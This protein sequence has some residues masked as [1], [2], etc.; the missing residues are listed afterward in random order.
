[1][2]IPCPACLTA[3]GRNQVGTRG[4]GGGG[5]GGGGLKAFNW[6]T[7]STESGKQK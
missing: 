7:P 2:L 6:L 1:M 3:H 5:G 4:G